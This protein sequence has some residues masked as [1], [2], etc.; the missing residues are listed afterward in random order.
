MKAL[1]TEFSQPLVSV[2]VT[3]R[4]EEKNI[5][6]CLHSIRAQSWTAIEA[7][8]VDNH[9]TDATL[10]ISTR[11]AYRVATKGPERSAQR[12]TE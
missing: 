4:N 3:T 8:V 7:I 2:V 1:Q 9:S 12:T 5:G 11:L 6:K 10:E